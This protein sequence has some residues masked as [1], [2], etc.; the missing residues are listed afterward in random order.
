VA[1]LSRT[2]RDLLDEFRASLPGDVGADLATAL[3]AINRRAE[4]LVGFVG[5]YRSLSN[6]PEARLERIRLAI[7]FER[8]AVLVGPAWRERGGRATFIVEPSRWS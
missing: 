4:S 2:A 7:L 3:D 5:S 6:L 8:V 1:S